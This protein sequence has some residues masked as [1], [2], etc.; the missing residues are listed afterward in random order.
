MNN[1]YLIY[2]AKKGQHWTDK[3]PRHLMP[4]KDKPLVTVTAK[5][6]YDIDKEATIYVVCAKDQPINVHYSNLVLADAKEEYGNIDSFIT[7]S[8]KW[9]TK[10]RTVCL[11]GDTYFSDDAIKTIVNNKDE[12]IVF[13]GRKGWHKF[14]VTNRD[15]VFCYS[16]DKNSHNILKETMVE[17]TNE[18]D[19]HSVGIKDVIDKCKE[20]KWITINDI[21]Q[22]ID[23]PNDYRVLMNTIELTRR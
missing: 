1:I 6:I 2:C 17:T 14:G 10:G 22:D 11:M 12:G 21:T 19:L 8:N 15:S 3:Q 9:N 4:I 23:I 18:T 5:Q 7:S 16:F 20:K 13:F